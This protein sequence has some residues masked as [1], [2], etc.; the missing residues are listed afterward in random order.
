MSIFGIGLPIFGIGLPRTGTTS[1]AEALRK[2]GYQGKDYCILQMKGTSKVD[3]PDFIVNNGFF[4]TYKELFHEHPDSK[5]ILTT[6]EIGS[7]KRSINKFKMVTNQDVGLPHI[8]TYIQEV[9]KFFSN[10]GAL[11]NL[12]VVD[13]FDAECD[14]ECKWKN[15]YEFLEIDLWDPL[16]LGTFPHIVPWIE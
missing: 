13:L 4:N 9:L 8:A 16:D 3:V 2:L 14:C 7:W 12:L 6:R 5:F 1:L 11:R 10:H 15:L